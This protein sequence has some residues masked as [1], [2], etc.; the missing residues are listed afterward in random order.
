MSKLAVWPGVIC[1]LLCVACSPGEATSNAYAFTRSSFLSEGSDF[2]VMKTISDNFIRTPELDFRSSGS[3]VMELQ[4]ENPALKSTI[5][6]NFFFAA[7]KFGSFS[8][9]ASMSNS[10]SAE[11]VKKVDTSIQ[12]TI[13]AHVSPDGDRTTVESDIFGL[14]MATSSSRKYEQTLSGGQMTETNAA[15]SRIPQ[16][17]IDRYGKFDVSLIMSP[18]NFEKPASSMS[19][20]TDISFGTDGSRVTYYTVDFSRDLQIEDISFSADMKMLHKP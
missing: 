13:E 6:Q 8:G 10:F 19:E 1:V 15:T 17:M 12:G 20:S 18:L 2:S 4:L 11:G 16:W 7:R 9:Y 3:S 5:N 14:S